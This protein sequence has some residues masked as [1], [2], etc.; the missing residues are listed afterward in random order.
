[1]P[2]MVHSTCRAPFATPASEFAVLKP[3]SFWQCVLMTYCP[4]TFSLIP[5]INVPNSW[6]RQIPTVSGMFKV[7]APA[8]TTAVRIRHRNSG[9][10]RPASSGENSTSSHPNDRAYTTAS[11]AI[12]TTSSGVLRSLSSMWIFEVAMKVWMRGRM[13]CLTPSQLASMSFL[14]ARDSPQMTGTYP[15]GNGS[16]PT[17]LAICRT[18]SRSSGLAIGKPASMIST[19]SFARFRAMSSFSLEVRVAPGDCS[20]SRNVV[21]NTRT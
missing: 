10:L 9:S 11:T 1:M 16:F 6:G 20:P 2:L 4:L 19:P 14:F 12:C 7:V 13:A 18:A 8:S 21:S 15:S 3:R 5:A 17:I